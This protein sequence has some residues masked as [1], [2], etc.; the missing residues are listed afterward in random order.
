LKARKV[1]LSSRY[2][3]QISRFAR[4]YTLLQFILSVVISLWLLQQSQTMSYAANAVA[5]GFLAFS[6]FVHGVWLEGR[7]T[8][9]ALEVLR[10]LALAALLQTSLFAVQASALQV[11]ALLS[12]LVCLGYYWQQRRATNSLTAAATAESLSARQQV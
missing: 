7:R 9:V 11:L 3:P 12:V 4:Y 1:D 2:D 6:F 10:L 8:A 5:V